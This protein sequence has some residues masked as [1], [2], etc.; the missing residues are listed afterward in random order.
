MKAARTQSLLL[1]YFIVAQIFIRPNPSASH[2]AGE[3][4]SADIGRQEAKS[5]LV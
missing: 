1:C 5:L 4:K 2:T 3:A